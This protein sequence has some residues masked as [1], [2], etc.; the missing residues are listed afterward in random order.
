M[1]NLKT[2]RNMWI[3]STADFDC[4]ALIAQLKDVDFRDGHLECHSMANISD[5]EISSENPD[6]S[7]IDSS[8]FL[9]SIGK[10]ATQ[11]VL[12]VRRFVF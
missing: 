9:T 6:S 1:P 12:E 3:N 7:N 4:N 2:A 5:K 8:S 11:I 10:L